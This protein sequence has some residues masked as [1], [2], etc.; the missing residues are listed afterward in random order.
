MK[1]SNSLGKRSDS[2]DEKANSLSKGTNSLTKITNSLD[3]KARSSEENLLWMVAGARGGG[4]RRGAGGFRR[5]ILC[6]LSEGLVWLE[7]RGKRDT[8]RNISWSILFSLY[9]SCYISEIWITFK[10]LI[11]WLKGR[12]RPK[13][14]LLRLSNTAEALEITQIIISFYLFVSK[15]M[16]VVISSSTSDNS[17]A[18][19]VGS[20]WEAPVQY[21]CQ[22]STWST[23]VK[24]PPFSC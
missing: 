6:T 23:I 24:N 16:Y 8:T 9:I 18:G 22:G 20:V 1:R 17:Y 12:L 14:R 13:R 7:L 2:S 4:G 3:K 21:C 11:W 10:K 15:C 19:T 5:R